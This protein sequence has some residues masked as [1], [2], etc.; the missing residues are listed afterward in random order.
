M[1]PT[2]LPGPVLIV[3]LLVA[4]IFAPYLLAVAAGLPQILYPKGIRRAVSNRR[5]SHLL[6]AY[7][8]LA[9][10]VY[11]NVGYMQGLWQYRGIV[12]EPVNSPE[13]LDDHDG[14]LTRTTR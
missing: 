3:V 6:D 12:A 13:S 9:Q 14:A 7:V 8:R 1:G 10:E 5:P 11:A 4:S 2:I